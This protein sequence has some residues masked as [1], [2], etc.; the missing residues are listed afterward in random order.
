M[1]REKGYSVLELLV[2]SA[3]MLTVSGAV[4]VLLHDGLAGTPILEETTDL[5]QRARVL[6]DALAK[7]LRAAAAGTPSGPL[8]RY[9]AAVDPRRGDDPP[10]SVSS[11][12]L[13][14]R[15]VPPRSAHS[16]LAQPLEPGMAVAVI[17]AIDGCPIG[18]IACGFV[19]GSRAVVFDAAGHADFLEIEAIGPGALTIDPGAG[20]RVISYAAGSEIAEAVEVT[21]FLDAAARQVRRRHGG[22]A[23]AVADNVTAMTFD[24]FG[25]DMAAIPLSLFQDGPFRGAGAMMFDTDLLRVRTVRAT[26]RL[27]TGVDAMRGRDVRLFARPGTATGRRVIPDIVWRIDVSLR[28]GTG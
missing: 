23:L 12:A 8:S 4:L 9:F 27:E 11:L 17:E 3:V 24:Y 25:D 7:E 16:R 10:G 2:A 28:N 14:L 22:T 18:T 15:Y 6:A 26:I 1:T 21:Y 19:A 13:T 5:H 20:S